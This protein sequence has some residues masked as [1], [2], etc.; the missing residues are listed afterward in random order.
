LPHSKNQDNYLLGLFFDLGLSSMQ[1]DNGARGFSWREDAPLKMTMG[2][3]N[4]SASDVVNYGSES[5]LVDIFSLYGQEPQSKTLAR[6]IIKERQK[7]IFHTTQQLAVFIERNLRPWKKKI[8]RATL[9]FQA[10]R[11]YVNEEIQQLNLMCGSLSQCAPETCVAF[12]TFHSLEDRIVKKLFKNQY[13][14]N[15]SKKD[16]WQTLGI[17]T[18]SDLEI[19][20]NPRARSAKLRIGVKK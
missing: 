1:L 20:S 6:L 3:N 17:I 13:S 12:L 4:F 18:P 2:L 14:D 9:A 15:D 19:Q 8:H 11:I 5:L 16:Q 10:I 7:N